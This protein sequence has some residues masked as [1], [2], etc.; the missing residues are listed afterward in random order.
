MT[1]LSDAPTI[2]EWFAS[3]EEQASKWYD[4]HNVGRNYWDADYAKP[5]F[6]LSFADQAAYDRWWVDFEFS[7]QLECVTLVRGRD[8]SIVATVTPKI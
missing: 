2:T 6:T 3:T 4:D 1:N 5:E 7:D 8:G